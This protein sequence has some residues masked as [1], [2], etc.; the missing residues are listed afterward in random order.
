[1][2]VRDLLKRLF[3]LGNGNRAIKPSTSASQTAQAMLDRGDWDGAIAECQQLLKSGADPWVYKILGE[4]YSGKGEFS[5]ALDSLNQA[6]AID[7]RQGYFYY[8]L[9]RLYLAQSNLSAAIEA[10]KRAIELDRSVNWF[11]YQLGE[12]LVKNGQWK[13]AIEPLE[14]AIQLNPSF[15]WAY[16]YLAEAHLALAQ[17]LDRPTHPTGDSTINP[18][19]DQIQNQT[20]D[21]TQIA[22]DLYHR[23][24]AA[25]PQNPDID[26][27]RKSLAYAQHLEDQNQRI[28]SFVQTAQTEDQQGL[29]PKQRERPLRVLL[30]APYP[31]YPPK[32]GGI[33]RMF[34]EMK[35]LGSRVTLVVSCFV[36]AKEDYVLERDLARYC[37]LPLTVMHGDAPTRQPHEPLLIHRYHSQRMRTLLTQL[38]AAQFDIV[39]FDMITMAQYRDLFPGAF[40]VLSEQNIESQLLRS[41]HQVTDVATLSQQ[42]QQQQSVEAFLGAETEA[43]RLAQYETEQWPHFPL[44]WVVSEIDKAELDR[45]CRLGQT[46]LGKTIVVNNGV[47]TKAIQPFEDCPNLRILFI[48]TLSYYPNIDGA[49]YLIDQI[50]PH[51]WQQDPSV[52]LWIAGASPAPDLLDRGQHPNIRIIANPEDMG[53]IA[54]QC[55]LTVVPLRIG[56]GT[57]IKILQAFGM[58]L[59][60]VTTSLG[61]SGLNVIDQTHLLIEDDPQAFAQAT[62]RLLHD[63][64]LRETLRKNG[65]QLVEQQYDWDQIY[66]AAVSGLEAEFQAWTPPQ[67]ALNST[68]QRGEMLA[69]T[70][71][72]NLETNLEANLETNPEINLTTN[73]ETNLETNH[74]SSTDTAMNQSNNAQQ[75][76]LNWALQQVKQDLYYPQ[77]Y[78]DLIQDC[79]KPTQTPI[80]IIRSNSQPQ[81]AESRR[82][83]TLIAALKNP[84][85]IEFPLANLVALT[86]DRYRYDRTVVESASWLGDVGTHFELSSSFGGKG[87]I[88]NTIVRYGQCKRGIEL[89]TAYGMSALFILEAM[90]FNGEDFHLATLE[91]QD[92]Q[93]TLASQ[94]LTSHYGDHV[95]CYMGWTEDKVPEM[96]QNLSNLDFMFHDAGHSKKHYIRDFNA[97]VPIL[98]PGAI[99][100]IDDIT[101]NDPRFC[102]EDPKTYEGWLEVARHPR[103]V[104]AV[105]VDYSL[106]LLLLK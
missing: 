103:V 18:A 81:W 61:C 92:P 44:R 83:A 100:I 85:A 65:R 19:L 34:H 5:A 73:L 67:L 49:N 21:Q 23:A 66:Q 86:A 14:Q 28:R 104:E 31:T 45:R 13:A 97:I 58:G 70:L 38:S 54:K 29:D 26:Y 6:I 10:C 74:S 98:A 99:V 37:H 84:P 32:L 91:G 56:S 76:V 36:F 57:R 63:R 96:V 3:T 4:A 72:A 69:S 46:I 79:L 71:E 47:D 77:S 39:I 75:I 12:L 42:A 106:G 43:D 89:G 9:A 20:Q 8:S 33:T 35:T 62:L 50:L 16:F 101:W 22:I 82:F 17:N 30:L 68:I 7:S 88:L 80:K 25:D 2:P 41:C 105:E 1:M 90:K 95:S 102:D 48:G 94:L 40:H 52:E 53:E 51:L 11:H 15:V 27:I 93:F 64:S 87:R 55:C 59:P 24:I 78:L 60:I